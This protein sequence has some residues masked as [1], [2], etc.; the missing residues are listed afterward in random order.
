MKPAPFEYH[1][2]REVDAALDALAEAGAEGKVLA[3]GQSL[4]PMLNMRLAAPAHLVDINRV[5]ALAAV[6]TTA[7]GVRVGALARHAQIFRSA[8]VAAVQP[9]LRQALGLVAHPAI[10]SRGTVVGSLVHADPAAELPAVLALLGGS[11]R[12][13]ARGAEREVAARD[14]FVGPME[15]AIRPGELAVSAFFP[16]LGAR[17]GTAFAEV[18]RRHGDYALA[19]V[20]ALVVLDE[21]LRVSAARVAC[22]GVGPVPLV[23]D[24]SGHG[25][26]WASAARAVQDEAEP[27]ADIHATAEYRRHLLGV[28]TERALRAAAR[29][30]GSD[31]GEGEGG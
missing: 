25:A 7:R 19:G 10:R 2:P 30:A 22:I 20:C 16:A 27:E 26:D 13:A 4:I 15:A 11:V 12:L 9:L 23:L 29:S 3:G 18:A 31:D 24:V 6:E 5:S 14:F 1:A 17:S 8:P 21:D 28:L